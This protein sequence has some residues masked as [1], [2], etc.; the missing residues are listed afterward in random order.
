MENKKKNTQFISFEGKIIPKPEGLDYSLVPGKVYA[1][2]QNRD[3]DMYLEEDKDFEFPEKYYLSDDD[4]KFMNK[5]VSMY[6]TTKK[7]T[8]GTLLSGMKGSGKTLMAKKIASM[9]GLPI[10]VIDSSVHSD[11]IEGFFAKIHDD[12]CVIMDEIDK[13]WNTRYLLGFLDGVKPTCKKLVVATCNNEKEIDSYLNDRCSRIRYKKTFKG[14]TKDT[15]GGIINDIIDNKDKADAAAEYICSNMET[16]SH[17]NV[18][19]FGEEIKN[20]PDDS[21]DEIMEFLNIS[22]R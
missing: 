8:L 20:N 5:V 6:K 13:Y 3:F 12:V 16:V 22:K 10:I 1:L 2:K 18:I 21:F 11:D 9:S 4:T 7:L 17:D 19:I 14:L 15:V